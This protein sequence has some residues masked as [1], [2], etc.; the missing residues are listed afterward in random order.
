MELQK[1]RIHFVHSYLI[2]PTNPISVSLI[3]AG[4]NGSQMLTALARINHAL[5]SLGHAGLQVTVFDDD[6][7]E[8]ANLGRQLFS[9][10][11]LGMNKGVALINRVNRFFGSGWKAVPER[12]EAVSDTKSLHSRKANLTVSCVDTLLA[13]A[14]IE[15]LIRIEH[16]SQRDQGLY[17]LDLGNSRTSGQVFLSTLQTIKQPK[18][19][20]FETV[21]NLSSM[22]EDYGVLLDGND[23]HANDPSCSLAEAL[24][25]QDLFINSALVSLGASMLWNLFREGLLEYRGFFLNLKDFRSQPVV[26]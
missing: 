3:G 25:K 9:E 26:V 22:L 16:D 15:H 19:E 13:R 7:V 14:N 20:R 5:C 6:T 17:L 24:T 10:S 18:S 23:Q 11:E 2:N 4:G 21:G 12:F 8:S 1:K